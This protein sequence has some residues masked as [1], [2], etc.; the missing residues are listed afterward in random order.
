MRCT[1]ARSAGPRA[2]VEDDGRPTGSNPAPRRTST[3]PSG[4]ARRRRRPAPTPAPRPRRRAPPP[5]RP[6]A[7]GPPPAPAPAPARRRGRTAAP[8]GCSSA[9]VPPGRA[10]SQAATQEQPGGVDVA[11]RPRG[12]ARVPPVRRSTAD[13]AVTRPS[14]PWNGGLPITRSNE[15]L[16]PARL[17]PVGHDD[18]LLDRRRA[19]RPAER[20]PGDL[21]RQRI[22]VAPPAPRHRLRGVDAPR[23]PPPARRRA[24]THRRPPPGRTRRCGRRR[25]LRARRCR[26]RSPR[27]CGDG[28]PF[29][30]RTGRA[31]PRGRGRGG[32]GRAARLA[33]SATVDPT[34]GR[35]PRARAAQ[36]R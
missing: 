15:A 10:S 27:A 14:W 36:R 35:R 22:E 12:R 9:T 3:A 33:A 13:R 16:P 28:R 25:R 24:G 5:P 26:R 30:G 2:A 6:P 18:L 31:A 19:A 1:G 7:G 23:R 29:G 34:A 4:A 20:G 11:A 32:R 17:E 21:H 8:S